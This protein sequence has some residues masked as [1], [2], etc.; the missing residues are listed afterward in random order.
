MIRNSTSTLMLAGA[1]TRGGTA[2]T[3]A[4]EPEVG[5]M[6]AMGRTSD[7]P[8][9]HRIVQAA[10][11]ALA[12]R[13]SSRSRGVAAETVPSEIHAAVDSESAPAGGRGARP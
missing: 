11:P 2:V 4:L 5:M 3:R 9:T 12:L 8:V 1:V 7:R 6:N 13:P 10:G